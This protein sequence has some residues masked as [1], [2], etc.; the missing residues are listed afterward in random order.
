MNEKEYP[1]ASTAAHDGVGQA[2]DLLLDLPPG[3]S[4]VVAVV[5]D[6]YA[7][8]VEEVRARQLGQR[9]NKAI[10]NDD[11]DELQKALAQSSDEVTKAVDS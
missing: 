11:Y 4:A 5:D 9:I 6:V 10:D 2:V 1:A 3:S 7:D 8:K